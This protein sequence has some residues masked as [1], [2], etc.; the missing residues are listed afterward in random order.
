MMRNLR[1]FELTWGLISV[2][3]MG[4]LMHKGREKSCEL[5]AAGA[6]NPKWTLADMV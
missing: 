2:S 3:R 5:G 1:H 6:Y 4:L